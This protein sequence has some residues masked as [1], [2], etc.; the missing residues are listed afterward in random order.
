[1]EHH[2]DRVRDHS[3]PTVNRRVDQRIEDSVSRCVNK[4]HDAI[5]RRISELDREWDVDRAVMI[6]AAGISGLAYTVELQR[7]SR[8]LF[9]PLRSLALPVIGVQ[10]AFLAAYATVGWAP[11]VAVL[12]RFGFRTKAE[13]ETE[14]AL[15]IDTLSRGEGATEARGSI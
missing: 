2:A 15:L 11:P 12:R 10:L 3:S 1:M 9:S 4:G 14:R 13:I 7:R 6:L 5:I 8:R